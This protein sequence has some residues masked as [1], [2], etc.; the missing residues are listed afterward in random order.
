MRMLPPS[1]RLAGPRHA[2]SLGAAEAS[3][4]RPR[5]ADPR[6]RGLV[7]D[8]PARRRTRLARYALASLAFL[9]GLAASTLGETPYPEI[10]YVLPSAVQRGTTSEVTV[11]ARQ[12][13]RGFETAFQ[14]F[15]SGEGLRAEILPR[16][17]KA[18]PER[19]KL[20][21][22]VA[23]DALLGL[24]EMRVAT[25]RGVSSLGE[26][27]VVDHPVVVEQTEDHSTPEKAQAVEINRV[28]TG[29][30]AAKEQV[31]VY[32]FSAQAGQEATFTLMGSRLY[33]KRHYQE[34]GNADPMLVLADSAG[35]E[36][37]VSD[38]YY[39]GDPMLH[40]RFEH[41]GDYFLTVRDVDY[42]GAA[43]FTYALTLTDGPFV[44]SVF[45]LAVPPVGPWSFS[46]SGFN[47]QG[48][49]LEVLGLPNPAPLGP[50]SVQLSSNGMPTNAVTVEVT[51]LPIQAEAEPND[52][53]SQ[54]NSVRLMPTVLNGR[55]DQ[56]NDVDNYVFAL[57]A[58]RPVRF[59]VKAR[60]YGSSLDSHLRL[61]NEKGEPVASGDDSPHTKDSLLTY[62]PPAEGT[63]TLQVRDLLYRGGPT[64]GYGL[65]AR[66]DEP[67]FELTCDDDRAGI[68]PGGAVP[69]FV[70]AVRRGGFDGPIDVHVE[71]LPPGVTVNPL[72]IPPTMTEGC[73]ILQAAPD[74][75]PGA[76][77]VRVVARAAIKGRDGTLRELQRRV[78][79]LQE[80][81]MG[82]GGRS[83]WPVETQIVQVVSEYDIAAVK[84]TP[85][86]LSLKPG[87][88]V[89]LD[90]EVVRRPECKDRVTLDVQ[91]Q[92]LG[93]VFGNPLPPGVK[94]VEAGSKTSLAPEESKG[95]IILKADPDAK[96]VENVPI[97]VVAYISI[98]FVVKRAYASA[99]IWTTI[100]HP[101]AVAA[102][103]R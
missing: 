62:T 44:T 90:V 103:S 74:A 42:N 63:Y 11:V 34:G 3:P 47:L 73:L 8:P 101:A 55:M 39:F 52:D 35:Q 14:A 86:T 67:D 98:D 16:E 64:Y 10:T 57:K 61:L 58:G 65:V 85:A 80:L 93:S 72:T 45:P 23:P 77:P 26:I 84:A 56:P 32:K 6:P 4:S 82:G 60:R 29:A 53:R 91:L 68:G 50:R 1:G 22:T 13:R 76:V 19:A 95:R 96:P 7:F 99:P 92:H 59:E 100:A 36:I 89:A 81:Y 75:P 38:D 30:I 102:A 83:V 27:L 88:Q 43:H 69:W 17:E 51:D 18:P 41:E 20:Q 2:R 15:F 46:A 78:Q 33:F 40:Y 24:R 9:A 87:E 31:D 5:A 71:G 25:R 79:P 66:E 28:V 49:P 94:L 97:A 21:V 70:R 48:G 37:A 54:A 12:A